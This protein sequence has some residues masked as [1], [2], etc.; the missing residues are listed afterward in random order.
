[1]KLQVIKTE[2]GY[3]AVSNEEIKEGNCYVSPTG[4]WFY[5]NKDC[6]KIIAT[7]NSFKLEGISQFELEE[8]IV[9][10]PL[11]D[12][13]REK[14]TQEECIGFIAGYRAAQSKGCYTK[15]DLREVINICRIAIINNIKYLYEDKIIEGIAEPKNLIAIEVEELQV[16]SHYSQDLMK[17]AVYKGCGEPKVTNGLLTVKNYIYE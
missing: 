17:V 4:I 15:E 5:T 9:G 10:K 11:D 13:I 1:M 12:Y 2:Q 7:D 8:T 6:K 16:F 3:V 14:H